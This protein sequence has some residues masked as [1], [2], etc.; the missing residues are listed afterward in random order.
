[1]NTKK[2]VEALNTISLGFAELAEA[3]GTEQPA[4]VQTGTTSVPPAPLSAGSPPSADIEVESLGAKRRPMDT[5]SDG[6]PIEEPFTE[7]LDPID[8]ILAA[9]GG[10]EVGEGSLVSC[11]KHHVLYRDGRYGK[12]CPNPSDDPAWSNPKGFCK[13]TPKNAA[14]YLRIKAAA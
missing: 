9:T 4:A 14:E 12:Y 1:M 11:P 5:F 2:A 7:E 3:L 13:I 8:P 6:T 10:V